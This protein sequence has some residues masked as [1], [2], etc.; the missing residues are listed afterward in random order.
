MFKKRFKS[1]KAN[2]FIKKKEKWNKNIPL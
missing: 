1:S 2:A